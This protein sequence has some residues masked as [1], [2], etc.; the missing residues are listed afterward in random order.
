MD[1]INII[2]YSREGF[3]SIYIYTGY[4]KDTLREV[5]DAAATAGT[6]SAMDQQQTLAMAL[7][8]DP[9]EDP[10]SASGGK[11]IRMEDVCESYPRKQDVLA[12]DEVEAPPMVVK[13]QVV[14]E[15]EEGV[16]GRGSIVKDPPPPPGLEALGSSPKNVDAQAQ[17][18]VKVKEKNEK[19]E[20]KQRKKRSPKDS[21]KK[22]GA[23]NGKKGK[24]K[25]AKKTPTPK[26]KAKAKGRAKKGKRD[27]VRRDLS[28]DFDEVAADA[29]VSPK[30]QATP[31]QKR[32]AGRGDE[33]KKEMAAKR[34]RENADSA[35]EELINI[36]LPGLDLPDMPY[37]KLSFV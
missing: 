20:K 23:K 1:G 11:D 34:R 33:E 36:Q 12:P 6:G 8:V 22:G 29:A 14:I 4:V 16:A 17:K 2:E 15:I 3:A 24:G 5:A 28:R 26:A 32:L 10:P 18:E 37:Q 7:P 35:M 25:G 21:T 31:R 9:A 30:P 13:N 19:E 27:P